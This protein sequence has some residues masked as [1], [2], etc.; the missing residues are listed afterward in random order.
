MKSLVQ[1]S[2]MYL[3]MLVIWFWSTYQCCFMFCKSNTWSNA[4]SFR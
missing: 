3:Q 2:I 1:T 4:M